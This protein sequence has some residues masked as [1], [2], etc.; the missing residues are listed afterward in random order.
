MKRKLQTAGKATSIVCMAVV[1]MFLSFGATRAGATV[2]TTPPSS[3]MLTF[4]KSVMPGKSTAELKALAS[5]PKFVAAAS[6]VASVNETQSPFVVN[7]TMMTS[8]AR[9]VLCGSATQEYKARGLF[10]TLFSLTFTDHACWD[11]NTVTSSSWHSSDVVPNVTTYGGLAGWAWT[12]EYKRADNYYY[13]L[14]GHHNGGHFA[15]IYHEFQ[16]CIG[17]KIG[18]CIS[19]KFIDNV[20]KI[21]YG[22]TWLF[23]GGLR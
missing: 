5:N 21:H 14:N 20:I 16:R 8:A 2:A 9:T 19:Q 3:Q 22:G 6:Q 12:G 15:G 13:S 7:K 4:L 11:G 18:Q 23:E 10:G 1:V 17:G